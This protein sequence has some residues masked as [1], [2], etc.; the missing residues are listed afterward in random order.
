[1]FAGGST[2]EAAT[3]VCQAPGGLPEEVPDA[4]ARLIEQ[5]LVVSHQQ[6][7]G[8]PRFSM[9]ETIREYALE[10]LAAN[11]E[12]EAASERLAH[13]ATTLAESAEP[14]LI[15][16]DQR[17]WLDR[18][19]QELSTLRAALSWCIDR[20]RSEPALRMG[21]AL[22]RFWATRGYLAEGLGWLC[23]ALQLPTPVAQTRLRIDALHA[24]GNLARDYGDSQR[25]IALHE[26]CLSMRRDLGDIAGVAASLGSLGGVE[27]LRGNY[28]R[29]IALHQ[30]SLALRRQ[31]GDEWGT[32]LQITNLAWTLCELGRHDE[33]LSRADEGISLLRRL[34]DRRCLSR[35]LNWVGVSKRYRCDLEG[36]SMLHNEALDI[37]R[38]LGDR[39]GAA[40]ALNQ[41]GCVAREQGDLRAAHTLLGEA[42]RLYGDLG[43]QRDVARCLTDIAQL[44]AV[45]GNWAAAVRAY[46]AAD[47]A[48]ETS[49]PPV[50]AHA[51]SVITAVIARA[52]AML[53]ESVFCA[54]WNEGR[55][56]P[57]R[58]TAEDVLK[59]DAETPRLPVRTLRQASTLTRRERQVAIL[60]A[61]G[62]TDRQIAAELIISERTAELTSNTSWPNWE[63]ARA[64]RWRRGSRRMVCSSR[65]ERWDE[66]R[67]GLSSG[68]LAGCA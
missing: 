64:P 4:I 49:G 50:A 46:A 8:E 44:A 12:L 17:E 67:A 18:L 56:L 59:A 24:A 1:M 25:A 66:G 5:S 7:N 15:R 58:Q 55:A 37:S 39:R 13:Y 47:A 16:Y 62:L 30:E 33:V 14:E 61:R 54:Q 21:R 52:R 41:L 20:H 36:A 40:H 26:E 42:F 51:Q 28:E 57:P 9:L 31:L 60:V 68:A 43:N 63:C 32:A 34:G 65:F 11:S 53:G 3:S 6:S 10:Q 19:D 35:L 38:N 2:A 22:W 48:F 29:A 23:A 27:R 45:S